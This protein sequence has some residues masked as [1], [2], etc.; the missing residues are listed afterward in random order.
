MLYTCKDLAS[1]CFDWRGVGR[2]GPNGDIR[3]SQTPKILLFAQDFGRLTPSTALRV[4]PAER[5][6][7]D[8]SKSV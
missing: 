5:L 7:F 3:M 4:T 8:L 6:R 1:K 2:G